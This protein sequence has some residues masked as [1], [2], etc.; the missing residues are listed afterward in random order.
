MREV[1]IRGIV[2]VMND[3][4]MEDRSQSLRAAMDRMSA[5]R[6]SRPV[7]VATLEVTPPVEAGPEAEGGLVLRGE[8]RRRRG[9]FRFSDRARAAGDS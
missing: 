3:R 1:V 8:P 6:G 7:P 9:I 5:K 2:E 4:Q